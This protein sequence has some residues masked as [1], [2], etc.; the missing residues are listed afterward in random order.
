MPSK[1]MNAKTTNRKFKKAKVVETSLAQI[2]NT[3]TGRIRYMDNGKF[4]SETKFWELWEKEFT[5]ALR[6]PHFQTTKTEKGNLKHE[7][8]F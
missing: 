2:E 1:T 4:I 7:I 6:I 3:K 5:T 8:Y